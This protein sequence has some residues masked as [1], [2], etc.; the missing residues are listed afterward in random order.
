MIWKTRKHHEKRIFECNRSEEHFCNKNKSK[1]DMN[2]EATAEWVQESPSMPP[3]SPFDDP[4]N[5]G[6]I[7]SIRIAVCASEDGL[8]IIDCRLFW[9]HDEAQI[10]RCERRDSKE[11]GTGIPLVPDSPV[12]R[13]QP[14][15][16]VA[17]ASDILMMGKRGAKPAKHPGKKKKKG[18]DD[19]GSILMDKTKLAEPR[20]LMHVLGVIGG[21]AI[22]LRTE[23][24]DPEI[25]RDYLIQ[26]EA[27]DVQ[28]LLDSVVLSNVCVAGDEDDAWWCG[29]EKLAPS[30]DPK[31]RHSP[32]S[33]FPAF[34]TMTKVK[35]LWLHKVD[36]PTMEMNA[37]DRFLFLKEG[38]DIDKS[39][40]VAYPLTLTLVS[41]TALANDGREPS[42]TPPLKAK[43]SSNTKQQA[44]QFLVMHPLERAHVN[45]MFAAF[46]KREEQL[47]AAEPRKA[48]QNTTTIT[49]TAASKKQ[50]LA[51]K[52]K[53]EEAIEV[54]EVD[55]DEDE[56]EEDDGDDDDDDDTDEG[57]LTSSSDL[58]SPA[59]SDTDQKRSHRKKQRPQATRGGK[60]KQEDELWAEAFATTEDLKELGVFG[61]RII[62]SASKQKPSYEYF[63]PW[64]LHAPSGEQLF[65]KRKTA[66]KQ[67]QRTT[68]VVAPQSRSIGYIAF[69]KPKLSEK[70]IRLPLTEVQRIEEALRETEDDKDDS[71]PLWKR[72]RTEATVPQPIGPRRKQVADTSKQGLASVAAKAR[73]K[74]L[75]KTS[76]AVGRRSLLVDA[77]PLEL[78]IE[79]EK[80]NS[81][82]LLPAGIVTTTPSSSSSRG[83][84]SGRAS[85]VNQALQDIINGLKA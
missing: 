1:T 60:E 37:P 17:Y 58:T 65:I 30:S 80:S 11:R 2:R 12:D 44:Q 39:T 76:A 19:D 31:L 9:L 83:S 35:I 20:E 79:N 41:A 48:P 38:Q 69:M 27:R 36:P 57:D 15:Y 55:E 45:V 72:A 77:E 49:S 22:D 10:A 26:F 23:L 62:R 61:I 42:L 33:R 53:K 78:I 56:E 6:Q 13:D 68:P 71:E 18:E 81:R 75:P 85:E 82:S 8:N 74:T 84:S 28:N 64:V 32:I 47:K 67:I 3:A 54:I 14:I 7:N 40:V 25:H 29:T 63:D 21:Q 66:P 16:R 50:N 59:S 46:L 24:I 51:S 4:S 73:R 34:E 52:K 43:S 5:R 70:L